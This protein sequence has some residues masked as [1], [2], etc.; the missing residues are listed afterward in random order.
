MRDAGARQRH[1]PAQAGI[2]VANRDQI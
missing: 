2:R 1:L